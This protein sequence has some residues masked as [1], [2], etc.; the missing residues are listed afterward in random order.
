MK[1]LFRNYSREAR[2]VI[3]DNTN[4]TLKL[5]IALHQLIEVVRTLGM[6]LLPVVET[7]WSNE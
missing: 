4:V 2:P 7:D 1:D 3:N 5:G 6:I